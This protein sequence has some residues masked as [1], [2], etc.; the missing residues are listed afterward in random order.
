MYRNSAP[1][2]VASVNPMT[3]GTYVVQIWSH[4]PRNSA[5]RGDTGEVWDVIPSTWIAKEIQDKRRGG[6]VRP[7]TS[8]EWLRV[9]CKNANPTLEATQGQI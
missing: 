1:W 5:S 9:R 4:T 2:M 3:I 8:T 6:G 7:S